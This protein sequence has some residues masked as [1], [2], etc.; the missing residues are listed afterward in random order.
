MVLSFFQA[1]CCSCLCSF[2]DADSPGSLPWEERGEEGASP[3]TYSSAPPTAI[4]S[5]ALCI[6]DNYPSIPTAS[7]EHI[8]TLLLLPRKPICSDRPICSDN[9]PTITTSGD[10]NKERSTAKHLEWNS[11]TNRRTLTVL[12]AMARNTQRKWGGRRKDLEAIAQILIGG[13]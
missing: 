4:S 2:C 13:Q 8:H 3:A 1:R 6:R 10:A 11:A 5:D 7:D 12:G 9:Q